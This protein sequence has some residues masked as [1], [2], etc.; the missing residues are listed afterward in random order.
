MNRNSVLKKIPGDRKKRVYL[1]G[2]KKALYI[3]LKVTINFLYQTKFTKLLSQ[4]FNAT[5]IVSKLLGRDSSMMD[6]QKLHSLFIY[7]ALY[8]MLQ[9]LLG[10]ILLTTSPRFCKIFAD[11]SFWYVAYLQKVSISLSIILTSRTN[12]NTN[13]QRNN[14]IMSA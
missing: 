3:N 6:L 13:N 4:F 8:L 11:F 2:S 9:I 7:T 12:C 1:Q 10:V 14:F 5:L